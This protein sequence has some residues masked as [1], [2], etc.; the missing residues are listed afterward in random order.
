MNNSRIL[1]IIWSFSIESSDARHVQCTRSCR[2]RG[3]TVLAVL[4]DFEDGRRNLGCLRQNIF[5]TLVTVAVP[6]RVAAFEVMNMRM[7]R[8]RSLR[9]DTTGAKGWTAVV[10]KSYAAPG[11][12]QQ[13]VR[14]GAAIRHSWEVFKT[15][16]APSGVLERHLQTQ[17]LLSRWLRMPE[18][19]PD[20]VDFTLAG[21]FLPRKAHTPG[22]RPKSFRIQS[23]IYS[24]FASYF[25]CLSVILRTCR[26][27]HHV[28]RHALRVPFPLVNSSFEVDGSCLPVRPVEEPRTRDVSRL[29]FT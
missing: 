11:S 17:C 2:L 1:P 25:Q 18:G 9:D 21:T 24:V 23:S 22:V 15:A 19:R 29:R 20:V 12:Y 27:Q 28:G 4:S 26:R 7:L 14:F 10:S 8:Q 3:K 13:E 6:L 5:D 16:Y